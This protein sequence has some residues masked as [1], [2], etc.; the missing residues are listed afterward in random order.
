MQNNTSG[1]PEAPATA[2]FLPLSR[3]FILSLF[4]SK[5]SEIPKEKK[6]A[7]ENIWKLDSI[8]RMKPKTSI[9]RRRLRSGDI[10]VSSTNPENR[11]FV[12][13]K[14]EEDRSDLLQ[15]NMFRS[16]SLERSSPTAK[17]SEVSKNGRPRPQQSD[18]SGTAPPPTF[19]L[20]PTLRPNS[21][22]LS[23]VIESPPL[24]PASVGQNTPQSVHLPF[25]L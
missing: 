17:R 10:I 18:I 11:V 7:I 19:N 21:P 25:R 15:N 23:G 22:R 20:I 1:A 16:V 6:Q 4:S 9:T 14:V 2:K 24:S 8:A 12:R 3:F 5:N 13:Q